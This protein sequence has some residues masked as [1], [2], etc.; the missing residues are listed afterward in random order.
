[1]HWVEALIKHRTWITKLSSRFYNVDM[2]ILGKRNNS[3]RYKM[4]LPS[5][6]LKKHISNAVS[7]GYNNPEKI[8]DF[9]MESIDDKFMKHHYAMPS[10]Q[11]KVVNHINQYVEGKWEEKL[12]VKDGN[13]NDNYDMEI[14][15]IQHGGRLNEHGR[16]SKNWRTTMNVRRCKITNTLS[17]YVIENNED[18]K[19]LDLNKS[20]LVLDDYTETT[21]SSNCI[22]NING[23]KHFIDLE[24]FVDDYRAIET[25]VE[26]WL[27]G[28]DLT[29]ADIKMCYNAA[30]TEL[31][32]EISK[33]EKALCELKKKAGMDCE[34]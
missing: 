14:H 2:T 20:Y 9:I 24:T 26:D 23:H 27:D 34:K 25:I 22:K 32:E 19:G 5:N 33:K 28:K 7:S 12:Y 17:S 10:E 1:M 29:K 21:D 6:C 16:P 13:M 18:Y 8:V 3:E 31:L 30:R 15:V 11:T 4:K